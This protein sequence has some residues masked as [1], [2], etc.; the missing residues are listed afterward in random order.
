MAER[1]CAECT[2]VTTPVSLELVSVHCDAVHCSQHTCSTG[3]CTLTPNTIDQVKRRLTKTSTQLESSAAHYDTAAADG[4]AGNMKSHKHRI[5]SAV[6]MLLGNNWMPGYGRAHATIS[7]DS[8]SQ[9][10]MHW[11]RQSYACVMWSAHQEL[12]LLWWQTGQALYS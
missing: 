9:A 11:V 1:C 12:H 2:V 7:A 6:L 10:C 8:R 5:G 3:T 4:T